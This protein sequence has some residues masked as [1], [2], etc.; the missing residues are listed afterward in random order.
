[1][2]CFVQL[3]YTI[4]FEDGPIDHAINVVYLGGT[5]GAEHYV[6]GDCPSL[7]LRLRIYLKTIGN[8]PEVVETLTIVCLAEKDVPTNSFSTFAC[9]GNGC[10]HGL[11]R[12]IIFIK[13]PYI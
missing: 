13:K 4:F 1:M 3:K 10:Y 8:D 5:L 6:N 2:V 12:D 11:L 7:S 9:E